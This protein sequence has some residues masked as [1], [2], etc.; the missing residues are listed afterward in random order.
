MEALKCVELGVYRDRG[1]SESGLLTTRSAWAGA[2]KRKSRQKGRPKKDNPLHMQKMISGPEATILKG[3][4]RAQL[5]GRSFSEHVMRLLEEDYARDERVVM[6]IAEP[7]AEYRKFREQ[8][9]PIQLR[10]RNDPEGEQS[11]SRP[12]D[13][14]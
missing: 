10:P 6:T 11:E 5:L 8:H 4:A 13:A 9:P 12:E 7:S 1:G 2:M 3:V 14:G